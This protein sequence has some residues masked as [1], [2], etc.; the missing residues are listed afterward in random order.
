MRNLSIDYLKIVLAFSVVLLH[1]HFLGEK[2]PE[3]S[4]LLVN[5]LF[6]LAVPLFLI[7][8]GYY[9]IHVTSFK[10]FKSWFI[11]ILILY[12]IW[13]I[14]YSPLWFNQNNILGI[15][16]NITIGYF[17]LWYLSGVIV[18]GSLLFLCRNLKVKYLLSIAI[19]FYLTGYCLQQI[20]NLHIFTGKL[21]KILNWSPISRNFLFDCFPLLAIGLLI[22]KTKLDLK[23]NISIYCV[24]LSI[25]LM[26]L[27]SY[28]NYIFVSK[29]EP[30][31]L[32]LM[33]LITAPIIFIYVKNIKIIGEN[34]NLSL[35][36]TAV[37][38]IHPFF[39][40]VHSYFSIKISSVLFVL[41]MSIIAGWL[42]I[43]IN[44]K[45]KYLL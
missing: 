11:R 7:I 20:G 33:I 36:S 38:L 8:T 12:T 34:K 27:E 42:L 37:F 39:M 28:I 1:L 26:V 25:F 19:I 23:I 17:V 30:L 13:M 9:F 6:R 3:L 29:I 18:G 35:F 41:V 15:I 32:L 22:N 45:V 43:L 24:I 5:G 14:F 21:D 4:F 10:K 31:D 2:F 16:S 44:K 40:T